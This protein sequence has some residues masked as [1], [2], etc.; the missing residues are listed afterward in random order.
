LKIVS[1]VEGSRTRQENAR[2]TRMEMSVAEWKFWNVESLYMRILMTV[3]LLRLISFDG[4]EGGYM[5][6]LNSRSR[7]SAEAVS[8]I[9]TY[10]EG[11]N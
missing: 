3:D 7:R 1:V 4:R 6:T 2:S 8:S 11:W 5:R 10:A 9:G